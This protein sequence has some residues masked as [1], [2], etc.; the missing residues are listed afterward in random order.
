VETGRFICSIAVS[1]RFC[2]SIGT[3]FVADGRADQVLV[4]DDKGKVRKRI[5]KPGKGL[6]QFLMPHMLALDADGNLFVAEVDGQ[7]MQKFLRKTRDVP[8]KSNR[9]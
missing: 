9:P 8:A 5:G 2:V 7:R 4:L 3:L 1:I 6:G